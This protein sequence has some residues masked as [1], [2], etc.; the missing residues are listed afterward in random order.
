MP[1][2]EFLSG[3]RFSCPLALT[4]S[5]R[6]VQGWFAEWSETRQ[7]EYFWHKSSDTKQWEFPDEQSA[8]EAM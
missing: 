8:Q 7:R 1:L 3:F 2:P 4:V 5:M 6:M